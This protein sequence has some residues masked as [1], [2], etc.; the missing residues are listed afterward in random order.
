MHRHFGGDWVKL[1][2]LGGTLF[3][4][5]HIV[6]A[7]LRRGFRVTTFTRGQ[8]NPDLFP[9]AE[10]LRGD[11]D[12]DVSALRGRTWDAVVDTSAY[13]PRQAVAAA[14]ALQ[15]TVGRY[16]FIST[17]SVYIAFPSGGAT[18]ASAVH[19]PP[20]DPDVTVQPET[21]GPLK[22]GC[23]RAVIDAFGDRAL[24]IRPGALAGPH[25]P[26][27]RLGYWVQRVATG[28]E[29]LAAGDPAHPVQLLDAR[30][31]AAWLLTLL[32]DGGA[33]ILNASGPPGL[34][35]MGALLETCRTVAASDARL[36]WADDAFL[37]E[38]GV[39]PWSD[40]PLWLPAD[41]PSPI[42]DS[43]RA[44]V[45]GLRCRPLSD[46]V[47]DVLEDNV[48]HQR[49]AGGLPRPEA[50]SLARERELLGLW[51]TQRGPGPGVDA[52]PAHRTA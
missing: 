22:V 7:A 35:T 11:R 1:L 5:R 33:G 27:G 37:L 3:L 14:A 17:A 6:D 2:L 46:T 38:R 25:D 43:R 23:E 20:G 21:Y 8:T 26:T 4:G 49:V 16:V 41:M 47:R 13:R 29:V 30:D 51:H 12:G 39:T 52:A 9:G 15:N 36:T 45:A 24:V 19:A 48:H 42:L 32:D 50:I 28:G 18:E 44:Y 31:L 10:K 34:L 40:L